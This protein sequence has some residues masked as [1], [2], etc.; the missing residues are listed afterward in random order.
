MAAAAFQA[1]NAG[2][3]RGDRKSAV[4]AR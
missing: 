4:A 2:Y 3:A 1:A